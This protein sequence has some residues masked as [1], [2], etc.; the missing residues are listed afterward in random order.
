MNE[1]LVLSEEVAQALRRRK[2]VVA[3]ETTLVTHGL[4]HPQGLEA[5]LELEGIVRAGGATPVTVGILD[6]AVRVGLA[7]AELER[8]ATSRDV[9]KVNLGNLG[10]VVASGVAGS[11]TVAAT[12]FVAAEAGI[13]VF[14]TGGIG[15][16]HRDVAESG[17]VSADLVALGRFPVAVVCAGAKAILDLPRTVEMLETLGVPVLGFGTDEFPAFYWR[18]SGQRVDRRCDSVDELA[19]VAL[20]HWTLGSRTGVLIANPIP[21]ADELPRAAYEQA[22]QG[23]LAEAAE[24]GLRGREVTPFLL[25]RLRELSGGATVKAN[26]ALLRN[27]ARVAAELARMLARE[28]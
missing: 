20:A 3:L 25:D 23:A 17:D 26:L 13:R 14:A 1:M 4:P 21:E 15:G 16:V 28:A 27:N 2:P 9:A 18:A 11:T 24:R 7:R 10:A 5:A 12:L 19:R 8:I 6:G 22:L